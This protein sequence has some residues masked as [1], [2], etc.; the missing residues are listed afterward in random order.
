MIINIWKKQD[1]G[2][3]KEIPLGVIS[4]IE[5][6]IQVLDE[7]YGTERT[8]EDLGGYIVV[9]DKDGIE[10]LRQHQL[11][12]IVPEYIDEIGGTDYISVL[13]LCSSDFSIVVICK[14]ELKDLIEKID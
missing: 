2:L 12:G 8:A 1:L 9:G 10:E 5:D 3:V 14:K 7:N 13:F 6:T 11:K 4:T